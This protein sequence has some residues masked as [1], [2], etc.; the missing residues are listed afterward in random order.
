ML[1]REVGSSRD[2]RAR[3]ARVLTRGAACGAGS[4]C[5]WPGS[6]PARLPAD[7]RAEPDESSRVLYRN[8]P[9]D[10]PTRGTHTSSAQLARWIAV[11]GRSRLS[12]TSATL[13]AA[14]TPPRSAQ[15]RPPGHG[16]VA[17]PAIGITKMAGHHNI[18]A[19]SRH[20]ARDATRALA[21]LGVSPA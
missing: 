21:A 18:A 8:P 15:A 10:H 2:V 20:Y 14:K 5:S 16:S 13:P 17:Q 7:Q 12:T 19:A 9:V 3:P 1:M 6:P 11:T 4:S